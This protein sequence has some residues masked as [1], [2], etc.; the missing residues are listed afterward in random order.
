MSVIAAV[1]LPFGQPA[2]AA[3]GCAGSSVVTL[4]VTVPFLIS[5][6][7][8]ASPPL[9]VTA[10]GFWPGAAVPPLLVQV[11]VGVPVAVSVTRMSPL[12][13]P[14]SFPLALRVV[15]LSVKLGLWMF[16]AAVAAVARTPARAASTK[17]VFKYRIGRDPFLSLLP[18]RRPRIGAAVSLSRFASCEPKPRAECQLTRP[19]RRPA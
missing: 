17:T 5:D 13:S 3:V 9:T 2:A 6:A 18:R 4:K 8:I 14:V 16:T 7:G 10:A 1:Q 19:S 12:P 11:V 15:P